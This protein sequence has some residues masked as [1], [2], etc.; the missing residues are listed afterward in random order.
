MNVFF[1]NCT[2][3]VYAATLN[4]FI[5]HQGHAA[6]HIKDIPELPHGRDS[7]DI[8]W[9]E[10]LRNSRDEWIFISGDAR[11]LKNRAERAALRTAKLHG[12]ILAAAYQKT[13][14]HRVA[15]TLI[16]RWPDILKVT[17]LFQP[18]SM[19]EIP[20]GKNKK[21]GPLSF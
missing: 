9:I 8:E 19:H 3:P 10:Y 6:L 1:D 21:L 16:L 11:I 15:A 12:F 7:Q 14:F 4:A 13:E 17:N 2:A 20:I 5:Q 18:P